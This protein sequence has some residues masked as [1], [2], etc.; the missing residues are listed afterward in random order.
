MVI[1]CK[2]LTSAY[3]KDKPKRVLNDNEWAMIK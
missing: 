1:Y 3:I 2:A